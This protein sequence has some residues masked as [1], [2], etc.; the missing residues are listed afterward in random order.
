MLAFVRAAA[1]VTRS[2]AK[3]SVSL[4]ARYVRE[5]GSLS[6]AWR[7]S[8]E[9]MRTASWCLDLAPCQIRLAHN[10]PSQSKEARRITRD[11]VINSR[12][13]YPYEPLEADATTLAALQS[14][15]ADP[16]RIIDHALE[17]GVMNVARA[18]ACLTT[19][20]SGLDVLSKSQAFTKVGEDKPGKRIMFC[21]WCASLRDILDSINTPG[22]MFLLTYCLVLEGDVD[23]IWQLLISRGRAL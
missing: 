20:R 5:Y 23:L 9:E 14:S 6:Q 12:H 2:H 16:I 3:S 18:K 22:V 13:Y 19:Y 4:S 17:R 15:S 11:K 21:L 8:H 1:A 7:P 10:T